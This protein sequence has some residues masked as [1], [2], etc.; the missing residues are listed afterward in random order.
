M[1]KVSKARLNE[2]ERD[3]LGIGESILR[4][5]QSEL[6]TCGCCGS[7]DTA[8]VGIWIDLVTTQTRAWLKDE[9]MVTEA[10]FGSAETICLETFRKRQLCPAR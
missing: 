8:E 5:E 1:L 7:Q 10:E 6:P 2:M 4:F 3:Y 9:L